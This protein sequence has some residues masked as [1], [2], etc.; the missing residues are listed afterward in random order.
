ML[1]YIAEKNWPKTRNMNSQGHEQRKVVYIHISTDDSP[2]TIEPHSLF[3]SFG[4]IKCRHLVEEL[5]HKLVRE[6]DTGTFRLV[7]KQY[8]MQHLGKSHTM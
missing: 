3:F 6:F 8:S 4:S 2:Y 7:S 5:V 1:P